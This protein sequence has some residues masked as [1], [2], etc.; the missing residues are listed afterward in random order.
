MESLLLLHGAL[1]NKNQLDPIAYQLNDYFDLYRLDF[2]GH[3]EAGPT[4]SPFRIEYFV[5][6]V[7]GYM[8]EHGIKKANVF[9][10]S[11]GGYVAL[12]LAKKYPESIKKIATLG[13]IL[14]WN[15]EIAEQE[16]HYLHPEKIKDKVPHFAEKLK[17]RHLSGWERVVERTRDMLEDLG[18]HPHIRKED[19]KKIKSSVRFHVGDRDNTAGIENTVEVY[20]KM[21][22][23]ELTVL[24]KTGHP[25][26]EVNLEVLIPSLL[27]FFDA[28]QDQD[29]NVQSRNIK[30]YGSERKN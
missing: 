7:L 30:G 23:S 28:A 1:G 24:P 19:W 15:P 9:G 26:S 12:A 17:E 13:T 2:E 11:M 18:M 10:Y 21:D 25:V 6:N 22:Y 20:K 27:E 3:G 29:A 16:C 4:G 5:E 14:Q 8:D